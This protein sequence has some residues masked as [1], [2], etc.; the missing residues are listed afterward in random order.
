MSGGNL[1]LSALF[2]VGDVSGD[3]STTCSCWRRGSF[4]TRSKTSHTLW[5]TS[6]RNAIAP[7]QHLY[8]V[9]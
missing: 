3:Q 2:V 9:A 6:A 8:F 4:E 1:T 7:L 5:K